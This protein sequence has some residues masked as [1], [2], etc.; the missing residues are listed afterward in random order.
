MT[1]RGRFAPS[2]SGRM[3]LGNAWT[4]LMAWLSARSQGGAVVLRMED[5]DPER[6]K[7]HF[8]RAI[9]QDLAWLGL[10]WDEG[11]DKGGPYGPYR[12]D[13]RREYYQRCLE[14]LEARGLVYPCWC[15]RAELRDAALAA[16]AGSAPGTG[17]ECGTPCVAHA[18]VVRAPHAGEAEPVYAGTCLNL[19]V[20]ERE[21]RQAQ[22]RRPSL[23]LAVP[24][25]HIEFT[26]LALGP[27]TQDLAAHCGDFVLR[28]ADGTHAYQL[29]V[30][31]DD[32]AQAIT[33]VVRGADLLDS[34]ARQIHLFRAFGWP[35]PAFAHV[36]LLLDP[37]GRR[38]SKRRGDV[39][40][41]LL[42]ESGVSAQAITGYLAWKA[43]LLDAPRLVSPHELI[44]GFSFAPMPRGPVVVGPGWMEEVA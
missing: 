2:P 17:H 35:E 34:T 28:R 40:L 31:A 13:E 33:E 43:G 7:E 18:D 23:R 19:S 26:D 42:R 15:T 36:P 44:D 25:L 24:A 38:L 12:Q 8:A 3:H 30:V 9:L 5:L 39:D 16:K 1:T 20:S 27:Q 41:G 14:L 4:A 6:S 29:A 21:A 22:G 37:D 11:P 10:D 32:A